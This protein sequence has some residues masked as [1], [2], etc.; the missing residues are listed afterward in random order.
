M[1]AR[2]ECILKVT[3]LGTRVAGAV[4]EIPLPGLSF[5]K[6]VVGL[7][8]LICDTA[9]VINYPLLSYGTLNVNTRG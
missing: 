2:D 8:V 6:P 4:C 3:T 5:L 1:R 7:A 9:K